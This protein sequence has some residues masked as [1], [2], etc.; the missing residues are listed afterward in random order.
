MKEKE[1]EKFVDGLPAQLYREVSKVDFSI[2]FY[3]EMKAVFESQN[4]VIMTTMEHFQW[5]W[6]NLFSLIEEKYR[7]IL[8]HHPSSIY[9]FLA[10]KI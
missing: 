4:G 5:Y 7:M 2:L 9:H 10:K 1:K 6:S 8:I 3:D